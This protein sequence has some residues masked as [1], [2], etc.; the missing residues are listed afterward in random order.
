MPF[1]VK[2]RIVRREPDEA[3]F[4]LRDHRQLRRQLRQA[5][6]R[7]IVRRLSQHQRQF[8]RQRQIRRF[9]E[10]ILRQRQAPIDRW[11]ESP[12]STISG[13]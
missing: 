5:P 10:H 2:A 4:V 6:I 1:G 8:M 7:V 9:A 12:R 3:P 13:H 11:A